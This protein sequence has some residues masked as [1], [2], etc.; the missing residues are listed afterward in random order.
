M[1]RDLKRFYV[2]RRVWVLVVASV[3]AVNVA[4]RIGLGQLTGSITTLAASLEAEEAK[5]TEVYARWDKATRLT[6]LLREADANMAELYR[7]TF[8]TRKQRYQ[9]VDKELKLL[10]KLFKLENTSVSYGSDT[11]VEHGIEKYTASFPLKGGYQSL[12]SFISHIEGSS[13]FLSIER[14]SL[15]DSSDRGSEVNLHITVVTYFAL[16]GAKKGRRLPEQPS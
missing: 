3:I 1:I 15:S 4:A 2:D 10:A 7:S 8:G 5:Y 9:A 11:L 14:V 13:Q 12:R 16:P 6:V